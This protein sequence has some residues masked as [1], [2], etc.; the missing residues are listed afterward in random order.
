M[1][2]HL[3]CPSCHQLDRVVN[4]RAAY[5]NGQANTS[6]HGSALTVTPDLGFAPTL[7]QSRGSTVSGLAQKLDPLEDRPNTSKMGC[8]RILVMALPVLLAAGSVSGKPMSTQV[9]VELVG[10]LAGIGVFLLLRRPILRNRDVVLPWWETY[11]DLWGKLFYC[12]RCDIVYDPNRPDEAV[13]VSKM[14]DY[15]ISRVGKRP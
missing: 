5:E 6:Q 13:H 4:V 3:E 14:H 1:D 7:M 15:L 10:I 11:M 8:G 9:V 2:T 12:E